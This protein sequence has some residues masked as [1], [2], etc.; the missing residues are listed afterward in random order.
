MR[1][2]FFCALT[3]VVF[4]SDGALCKSVFSSSSNAHM[5]LRSRRAN[6]FME[7]LKPASLE[8]EC[9][10][11]LCDF[12]EAREIFITREATLEFWTAYKDGNQCTTNPCVHGKC[13]DLLQ[14]FSCTCDSGFEGKHCDL[15]RTA[16]NCSLNNGDC[17]HDCHES[18]DGLARTCSC[19][20][21]YQL[22]DNSRKC[23]PKNDASCG[24]IRIPKSAYANKPKPV[25]QPWV[26][27]GNVG[28]RGES[29]WQALILNHLG[30]FHCG[31][32]LI[33]ENWVLT[34]AHCLETSS[35]FSVRLGDYQRFKFEGSEV[36]L[37]VKQHISHPQYNPITVDNDIALLRLDGPVK[38]S[39]YILPACLPSLELAKRMLHR[40]GTVT[41]ITGWGKNNQ[42]ATSYNSTLHYVELPIV[43]NKECSRHMMNNLSDNM[44]CA[45][46]LGQV[47]DA[48]EG[49]SGGPMM[50]LF[51][52]TWFLVGLVSW[53][54]GC[55]QRDKL[56]IY[57]KVASYLDWIDSVRQGWD[58]V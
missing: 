54:E 3:L 56:G 6:T 23:T 11:E 35:K 12:E 50:T 5:L 43:D 19:I 52:D 13:V 25:L 20:K 34:A 16:T 30:R 48:C 44:L 22:Q 53:G 27:G 37:P 18:K 58:K 26:M 21:G 7:E 47:K 24:Q 31:G 36:T 8:R 45:G 2:L 51:H 49:D 15:R 9:R 1:S 39:T 29:P 57:T 40:N 46:V 55:G 10:E 14:D 17:D 28:K 38:F 32:V 33:D 41:I 4:C 42:S